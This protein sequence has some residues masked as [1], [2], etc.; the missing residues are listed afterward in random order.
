M[1]SPKNQFKT[2]KSYILTSCL[3][4]VSFA[5]INCQ[6]A[7]NRTGVK[8]NVANP[9]GTNTKTEET[10][11]VQCETST[12]NAV[13]TMRKI[14]EEA[15]VTHDSSKG[16]TEAEKASLMDKRTNFITNCDAVIKDL[17]KTTEKA[18][19][20]ELKLK[21]G[22]TA[23]EISKNNISKTIIKQSCDAV[24]AKLAEDKGEATDRTAVTGTAAEEQRKEKERKEKQS[25][26]TEYLKTKL[27]L[28]SDDIKELS[29]E[30]EAFKK[31]IA[32]GEIKSDKALETAN[33]TNK[34]IVCSISGNEIDKTVSK[35]VIMKFSDDYKTVKGEDALDG[36]KG[37]ATS[38]SLSR[39]NDNSE[40]GMADGTAPNPIFLTLTCLNVKSTAIDVEAL[41]KAL[42]ITKT[43]GKHIKEIS[44]ADFEKLRK[45]NK[46]AHDAAKAE[47]LAAAARAE[48]ERRKAKG[49]IPVVVTTTVAAQAAA[50]AAAASSAVADEKRTLVQN[51]TAAR[52]A[53]DEQTT[54]SDGLKT[55]L[56]AANLEMNNATKALEVKKVSGA[57]FRAL[58]IKLIAA[59][60]DSKKAD[61]ALALAKKGKDTSASTKADTAAKA[62]KKSLD[63][64][65]KASVAKVKSAG[66]VDEFLKLYSRSIDANKKQEELVTESQLE[67]GKIAGLKAKLDEEIKKAKAKNVTDAE[68]APVAAAAAASA[69]AA[70]VM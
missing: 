60:A 1:G 20:I 6:K 30:K 14:K 50:P 9:A 34:S 28:V 33:S 59:R 11:K 39:E 21:A 46:A 7:P 23:E 22:A 61:E 62:A 35:S 66:T 32:G 64:L 24:K 5:I 63:E 43:G 29:K 40:K 42:G 19:L 68:L 52:G 36:F 44:A 69:A 17:D 70:T 3:V 25:R 47:A 26:A 65:E 67:S 48:E 37:D 27:V 54:K 56:D 57:D 4:A 51:V 2:S 8:P 13:E 53:L 12:K 58:A 10:G 55:K 15:N 38:V 18:C 41:K 49:G 45:E 16:K 31:Y